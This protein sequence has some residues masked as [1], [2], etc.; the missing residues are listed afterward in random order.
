MLTSL[1]V[2]LGTGKSKFS[3]AVDRS[4]RIHVEG[5]VRN[6]TPFLTK[7]GSFDVEVTALVSDTVGTHAKFLNIVISTLHRHAT[8]C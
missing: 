5:Q 1:S 6:G 4:G 8:H 7:I 3:G 2:S